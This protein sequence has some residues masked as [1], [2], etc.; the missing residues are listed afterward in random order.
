MPSPSR[1]V[2]AGAFVMSVALCFGGFGC[3]SDSSGPEVLTLSATNYQ[4]AFDAA[5]EAARRAGMSAALRDRRGGVIETQANVAG[6]I[7]EPWR[8]DNASLGQ[9]VENTLA[10]QRRRARFEFAPAGFTPLGE[11][12]PDQP[13]TGP[14]VIN[15]EQPPVDLSQAQ[16]DLELRV[17]VYVERAHISGVRRSTW[18]RSKT[19]QTQLVYPEGMRERA[20]GTVINWTPVARDTDYERRLLHDV[21]TAMQQA[22][23]ATLPA[24]MAA[25]IDANPPAKIAN[26]HQE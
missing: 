10:Y 16:G 21:E 1:T 23:A 24:E 17:W 22:A 15:A 7:L 19:T 8:T 12:P 14:D 6:S 25:A 11:A 13:L 3:A 5:V 26:N 18:T 9:A 4:Q 20:R 2:P